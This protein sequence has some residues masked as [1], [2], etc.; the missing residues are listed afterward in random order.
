MDWYFRARE[1]EI[2]RGRFGHMSTLVD[3]F[4]S[5]EQ[6]D[7]QYVGSQYTYDEWT[8]KLHIPELIEDKLKQMFVHLNHSRVSFVH[9]LDRFEVIG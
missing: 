7:V 2:T 3:I 4:P 6:I 5:L 1:E 8:K 9:S